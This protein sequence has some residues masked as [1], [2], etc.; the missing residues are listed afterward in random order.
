MNRVYWQARW[1]SLGHALRGIGWGLRRQANLRIHALA[2]LVVAGLSVG[3]RV[4]RWEACVLAL[5]VGQVWAAELL[6]TAL[7]SLTDLVSPQHQTRAGRAKDVAAGAVLVVAATSVVV[8][9]L[10][11]WPYV[12][13]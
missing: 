4:E 1:R 9:V 7:E 10:V 6:N 2:T 11:F 3:L 8:A 13:G 12:V 5:C